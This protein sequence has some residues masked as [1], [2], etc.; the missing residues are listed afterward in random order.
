MQNIKTLINTSRGGGKPKLLTPVIVLFLLI[1]TTIIFTG[2]GTVV[3]RTMTARAGSE[4]FETE[5]RLPLIENTFIFK[6]NS[7]NDREFILPASWRDETTYVGAAYS[8]KVD[9]GDGKEEIYSGIS[10]Y[11]NEDNKHTYDNANTE[12]IIKIRPN[13]PAEKDW[14]QAFGFGGA[15]EVVPLSRYQLKQLL[16][17][18]PENSKSNFRETFSSCWELTG[19]IKGLFDGIR[20]EPVPDMFNHTFGDCS[21]LTGSIPADL[22]SGIIGAPAEYMFACTFADS[23]FTGNIPAGLFKG[24]TGKP[25][26]GMFVHT[27]YGCSSLTGSIPADLFSGIINAP[28]AGMFL[29]TFSDCSGLTGSIPASLFGGING[30]P[31]DNMFGAT[32]LG[33]SGLTE[34]IPA[35]L[36]SGINGAPAYYMFANTFYGCSGLTSI[37]DGLFGNINGPAVSG[38]FNG[39]FEGCSNLTGPSA[40][41]MT[42]DG[43][44]YLYDD[45][46]WGAAPVDVWGY[47]VTD[48]YKGATGLD[49]Y[50]DIPAA[51][52]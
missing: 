33:C 7:G 35:G 38:M 47:V 48:C 29:R 10:R 52:K 42:E 44:K 22:F 50:D 21:G 5:Q 25:A 3:T 15:G 45:D 14:L 13:G 40:K 31:A 36:F 41:I 34:S 26:E 11:G 46:V 16:S 20:H 1:F 6:I 12:Y 32:F 17:A 23:G 4:N 27:F 24:I 51:W 28:A 19:T 30:E 2:C 9:W 18:F 49:D 37:P 39:T 43:Y 8:W